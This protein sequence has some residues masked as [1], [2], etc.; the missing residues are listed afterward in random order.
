MFFRL[1]AIVCEK[2]FVAKTHIIYN[3][4]HENKLYIKRFCLFVEK[5]FYKGVALY[6]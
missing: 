3:I 6:K 1:I 5:I 2:L 4:T